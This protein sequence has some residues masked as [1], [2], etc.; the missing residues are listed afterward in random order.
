MSAAIPSNPPVKP[1]RSQQWGL[2]M[3]VL[4]V[5]GLI[6]F[7]ALSNR[8]SKNARLKR[9][10]AQEAALEKMHSLGFD[11]GYVEAIIDTFLDNPLYML[12]EEHDGQ[13]KLW[14]KMPLDLEYSKKVSQKLS[15]HE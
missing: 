11:Q 8:Y 7:S 13:L 10:Q 15:Q 1:L 12:S 5:I 6:L 3:L 4:G 9:V 2:A 14:K